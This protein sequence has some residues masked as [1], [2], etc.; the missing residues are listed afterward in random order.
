MNYLLKIYCH[1]SFFIPSGLSKNVKDFILPGSMMIFSNK[2]KS[3]SFE[4]YLDFE[5]FCSR[6]DHDNIAKDLSQSFMQHE[7]FTHE[8]FKT[9]ISL[10]GGLD[11]ALVLAAT[12]NIENVSAFNV[13]QI[14]SDEYFTAKNISKKL[15]KN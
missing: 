5:S 13:S 7:N 1:H 2:K 8:K 6:D 12:K 14:F 4:W 9:K 11:S 10:S 15:K 3:Y